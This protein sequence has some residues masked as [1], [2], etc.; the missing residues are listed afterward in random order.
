M[1]ILS[2]LLITLVSTAYAQTGY[3]IDFKIKGLRDTTAYLGYFYGEAT[4]IK[5]T[6]RVNAQGAATFAGDKRLPSGVYFFV[7]N[8]TPMFNVVISQKQHF[9]METS[10][11]DYIQFMKV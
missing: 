8:K 7:L 4:Y 9:T 5:D 1:K 10:T 2:I 6:A 3:K 11:E